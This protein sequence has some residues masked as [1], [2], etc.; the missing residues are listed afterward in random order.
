MASSV[1]ATSGA[2]T[3]VQRHYPPIDLR[4]PAGSFFNLFRSGKLNDTETE[5]GAR[6]VARDF[7][8]VV[9]ALAEG[10]R[11]PTYLGQT[12]GDKCIEMFLENRGETQF[13]MARNFA[14]LLRHHNI[15]TQYSHIAES[16][17]ALHLEPQEAEAQILNMLDEPGIRKFVQVLVILYYGRDVLSGI[18]DALD[19]KITQMQGGEDDTMS[20]DAVSSRDGTMAPATTPANVGEEGAEEPLVN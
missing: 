19:S 4:D 6:S 8:I 9:Q 5:Y 3:S 20:T 14:L 10:A 18:F 12:A 13:E 11:N 15:D 1:A 17:A 7:P 16:I 2:F